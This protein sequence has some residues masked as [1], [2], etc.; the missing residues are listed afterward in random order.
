MG[1]IIIVSV[2]ITG[3]LKVKEEVGDVTMDTRGRHDEGAQTKECRW[4]QS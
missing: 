1:P 4:P 3:N 2:L